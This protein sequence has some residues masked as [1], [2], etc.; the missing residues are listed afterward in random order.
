MA[1]G[2]CGAAT[3][4]QPLVVAVDVSGRLRPPTG[5]RVGSRVTTLLTT[6]EKTEIFDRA[7]ADEP[8]ALFGDGDNA[9]RWH[10]GERLNHLIAERCAQMGDAE[11]VVTEHAALTFQELDSRA[12]QL[13]RY[14]LGQGIGAGDR[15]GLLFDK[16]ADTYVALLAVMKVNA[17]YVPLDGGFPAER[18]RFIAGDAGLKA[19]VSM[20]SF[21]EKLAALE[22]PHVLVDHARPA[23]DIESLRAAR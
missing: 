10:A 6:L 1:A 20:S 13:A 4:L 17:A 14:L 3:W 23:I 2:P 15:V 16:S 5:R 11:A 7:A 18:V 22:L 8:P 19:I 21:R 9:I 12:N